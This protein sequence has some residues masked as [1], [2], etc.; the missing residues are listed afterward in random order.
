[1]GPIEARLR[2][3]QKYMEKHGWCQGRYKNPRD[4]RV[5]MIGSVIYTG[6]RNAEDYRGAME[7]L[8]DLAGRHSYDVGPTNWNDTPG[9]FERSVH[10]MLFAAIR[11]AK[12]MGV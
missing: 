12:E 10:N 6:L 3:A 4:G 8:N 9:R 1:M 5:C 11:V 7:I 2:K